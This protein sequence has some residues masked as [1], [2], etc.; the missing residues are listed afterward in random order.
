MQIKYQTV[1]SPIN[2][3]AGSRVKTGLY[4]LYLFSV[5]TCQLILFAFCYTDVDNQDMRN[6]HSSLSRS[7]DLPHCVN[8]F[9]TLINVAHNMGLAGQMWPSLTKGCDE[10]AIL[11]NFFNN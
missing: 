10:S 11:R 7:V 5:S 9:G 3:A 6:S 8:R 2:L 4:L 1:T